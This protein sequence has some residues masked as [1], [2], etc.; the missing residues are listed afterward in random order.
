M[1]ASTDF[2]NRLSERI[3]TIADHYGTPFHIYDEAGIRNTGESLKQAFSGISGFQ[4]YFAVKALPNPR[5]LELMAAMGFGFDCSSIAEL[6]LSR[7]IGARGDQIMFTSTNTSLG[8][9]E[10]AA[11]HGGCVLNLDDVS[12]IDK[13]PEMPDRICFRY[14]PGSRRTGNSIIGNP[15]EA[16]YG[17]SHDQILDAYRKARDRGASRF[18]LHTMLASNELDYRYMVDTAHMLLE[19]VSWISS[20]LASPFEF[21]NIGGGLGIPYRPEDQALDIQAMGLEITQAF[22]AFQN[23]NGY[24]PAMFMESGRY[25][26]GPHG[27]LVTRAINRKEI[28]RTYIGVDACMSSLMRP[29]MYK[30]Y[31]H[32]TLP[33]RLAT[34]TSEVVDV[35]G[36][37]CENNDKFAIQRQLPVITDGDLLF[38]HDS[39]AHGHAMGFNYNGKLRPKELLLRQ[40]GGVELIRREERLEDYFATLEFEP[41]QL[42]AA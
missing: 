27:V 19:L 20:E 5:I 25:M 17:V 22:Q 1:P 8:E 42:P 31:H 13:V 11:A 24:V 38:I 28:Y 37:L 16:K 21:V 41:D 9:F 29:G 40:D 26:T 3:D 12:L 35:V 15:V 10:E 18:G 34:D 32:I 33:D 2:L 6:R 39:G 4:E 36:S 30:A 14:N 23:T 7:R